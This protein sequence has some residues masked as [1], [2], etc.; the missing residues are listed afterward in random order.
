LQTAPEAELNV[1]LQGLGHMSDEAVVRAAL[2]TLRE[3]A[4]S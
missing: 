4:E 1:L 2:R 3:A